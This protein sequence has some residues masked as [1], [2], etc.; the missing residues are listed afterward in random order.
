[1]RIFTMILLLFISTSAY[2]GVCQEVKNKKINKNVT[3]FVDVD[4]DGNLDK[5]N[6]HIISDNFYSPFLW[7]FTITS[8]E[9]K[10][11]ELSADNTNI[12]KSFSFPSYIGGNCNNYD[13]CKCKWYFHDFLDNITMKISSDDPMLKYSPTS[14]SIHTVAK[15]FLEKEWKNNPKLV[16]IAIQNAIKSLASGKLCVLIVPYEPE[17]PT[18]PMVWMPEFDRFVPI[19]ED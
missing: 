3:K 14:N 17:A 19:Y 16:E 7:N 15:K 5:I 4:G 11:Y 10:I 1:M 12:D 9:K 8:N 13:D 6:L 2:S 18:P